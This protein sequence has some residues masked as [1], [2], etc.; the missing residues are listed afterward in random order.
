MSAAPEL[1]EEG[2]EEFELV[3]VELLPAQLELIN[4]VTTPILI[5]VAGLGS[6]KTFGI[7]HKAV[8]LALDN[9]GAPGMV[10][11]PTNDM[12]RD[13]LVEIFDEVLELLDIDYTPTLKPH[14]YTLHLEGG[15][16]EIRLRSGENPRRIGSGSNLAWVIA[17]EVDQLKKNVVKR[18]R[19]RVRS[20]KAGRSQ[21]VLCG[22]PEGK[23]VLHDLAEAN[24]P[25]NRRTGKALSRV[26]RAKTTDNHHLPDDYA[27][28]AF[29]GMSDAE[30]L[31]FKN[32][33]FVN[34]GGRCYHAF[35]DS[36]VVKC[37]D[38]LEGRLAMFCD[39]NVDPM[40][41]TLGRINEKD[42]VHIW[43]E[44]WV[45]NTNT[46][47]QAE[48][49]AQVWAQLLSDHR[50]RFYDPF[51]AA[52]EVETYVDASGRSRRSSASETDIQLLESAGF[53]DIRTDTHNPRVKNRV[54]SVNLHLSA[55]LL[56]FDPDVPQTIKC[57]ENQGL[58]D[59]N[60]PDK[61]QGL[62][63]APDGIG[64]GIYYNFP[65]EYPKGNKS[66]HVVTY[67]G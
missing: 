15:D 26:I 33:E 5:L 65:G 41:W 64:Y 16:T 24:P 38:K 50:G 45:K 57:F 43:A 42:Q 44:I 30:I 7:V 58:D 54:W 11:M 51:E 27:D 23:L 31:Q 48:E 56:L 39:F 12:I 18:I 67:K 22:T 2:D 28:N 61:K 63:H 3:Q 37:L 6:G 14:N 53:T 34:P 55:G 17:D 60:E 20:K 35:N 4:D 13:V 32:G 19:T 66:T 1:Y 49:A 29:A 21:V 52:E 36:R 9:P 46:K 40:V 8:Q 25:K 62:D 59:N 47:R 10:V